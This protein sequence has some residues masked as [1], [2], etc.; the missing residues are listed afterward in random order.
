MALKQGDHA[1]TADGTRVYIKEIVP[2]Y[3]IT[4]DEKSAMTDSV[5]LNTLRPVAAATERKQD[6]GPIRTRREIVPGVYGCRG[7]IA[8][9]KAG[10]CT[11]VKIAIDASMSKKHLREAAHLFN[12]LAEV[13]EEQQGVAH[14]A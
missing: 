2:E 7:E 4:Y 5:F 9:S 3:A 6:S 14:A 10:T 1:L 11:M 12:Q 8:V 13:L